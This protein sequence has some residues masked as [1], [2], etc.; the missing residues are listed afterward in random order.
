MNVYARL[1]WTMSLWTVWCVGN[2]LSSLILSAGGSI[3]VFF[4]AIRPNIREMTTV[5][6]LAFLFFI[7]IYLLHLIA[8]IVGTNFQNILISIFLG[9]SKII[10][11]LLATPLFMRGTLMDDMLLGLVRLP[12]PKR[13]LRRC[14]LE[15]VSGK[16]LIYAAAA[17]MPIL[18]IPSQF[19]SIREAQQLRAIL[20]SKFWPRMIFLWRS[21]LRR[22]WMFYIEPLIVR[23][24]QGIPR[25]IDTLTLKG[26]Q[27]GERPRWRCIESG[28]LWI[29]YLVGTV[30]NLIAL[31]MAYL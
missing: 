18:S 8:I 24:I 7:Q 12:V 23:N 20:P 27:V 22:L 1:I 14:Q 21:P 29:I 6:I 2:N 17:I 19:Q 15:S 31:S 13:P 28:E 30:A 16:T 3:L 25:L 26:C 11:L 5:T 4:L 9:T 10:T